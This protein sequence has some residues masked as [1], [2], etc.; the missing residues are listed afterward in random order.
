MQNLP[1]TWSIFFPFPP[2]A[3][4]RVDGPN[5]G[6]QGRVRQNTGGVLEF[7]VRMHGAEVFGGRVPELDLIVEVHYRQEGGGNYLAVHAN[8]VAF[9]DEDAVVDSAEEV[10]TRSVRSKLRVGDAPL[11]IE[12]RRNSDRVALVVNG[13]DF[14][15][16][17]VA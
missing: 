2:G 8:G 3:V 13:Q 11:H 5:Q 10:F 4:F 6:G 15:L 17:R 14:T 9:E 7:E 1:N 16:D 12:L